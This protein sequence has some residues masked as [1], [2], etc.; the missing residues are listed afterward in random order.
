MQRVGR[1]KEST[2]LVRLQVCL[3]KCRQAAQLVW[4]CD[5]ETQEEGLVNLLPAHVSHTFLF[6]NPFPFT[7]VHLSMQICIS[8]PCSEAGRHRA[9]ILEVSQ[10]GTSA[11]P[12]ASSRA[13]CRG[14]GS[15]AKT[16]LCAPPATDVHVPHEVEKGLLR[17]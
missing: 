1:E 6:L 2:V 12:Q 5:T 4:M 3:M 13:G 9:V 10:A 7:S 14:T 11:E 8:V 16:M 15:A 17:L